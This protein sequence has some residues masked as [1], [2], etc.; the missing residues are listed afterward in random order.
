MLRRLVA[1]F[2]RR[3]WRDDGET[4]LAVV[5]A[6]LRRGRPP[7]ARELADIVPSTFLAANGTTRNRVREASKAALE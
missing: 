3:G 6:I 7:S 5:Q 1:E 4:A 2:E